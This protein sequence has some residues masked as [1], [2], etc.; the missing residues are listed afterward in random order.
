MISVEL[1]IYNSSVGASHSKISYAISLSCRPISSVSSHTK[2]PIWDH[3]GPPS[4]LKMARDAPKNATF[5]LVA[6]I[7][8]LK[9]YPYSESELRVLRVVVDNTLREDG[10][11]LGGG[12]VLGQRDVGAIKLEKVDQFLLLEAGERIVIVDHHF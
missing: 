7:R 8:R 4:S 5:S 2:S 3:G 9:P 1:K 11:E 6:V 12:F 10:D